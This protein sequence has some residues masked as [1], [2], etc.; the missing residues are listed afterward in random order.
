MRVKLKFRKDVGWN[1]KYLDIE[2]VG[3]PD[4]VDEIIKAIRNVVK[5]YEEI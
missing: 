1:A 5:G 2:I 4:V 3:E